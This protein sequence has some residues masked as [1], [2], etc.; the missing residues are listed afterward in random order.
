MRICRVAVDEDL[1]FGLIEGLSDAGEIGDLA[2][3]IHAHFHHTHAVM[4][5]Q[6]D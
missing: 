5:A 3:M 4:R 1:F 6:A 2:R